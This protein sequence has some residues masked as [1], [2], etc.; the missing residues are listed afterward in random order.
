M[1][2][3]GTGLLVA[4][5]LA[6]CAGQLTEVGRAPEMAP[7]G[8]GLQPKVDPTSPNSFPAPQ[9]TSATSLWDDNR[10][11]LFRDPRANRV[12]D[13][14]TVLIAMD[15]KATL[16]NTSDRSTTSTIGNGADIT[17]T[18]STA[19]TTGSF[20]LDSTSKSAASGTGSVDRSEKIQLSVGAVV[21]GVLPNGNLLISGS[22]EVR[23]NYELRQLQ[24]AGIVRP[25]DVSKDN[26]IAYDKIAEA[27]ISYGGRGR[28]S[29]VQ[30]PGWGQ[31]VYDIVKP[32]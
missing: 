32:F 7:V 8:A 16:D 30:Q 17:V 29:E 25:R 4:L 2:R 14:I 5:L 10:A 26:T 11:N 20:Q 1:I 19:K 24:V 3:I 6:G 13:V 12:G 22:Q 15:E 28:I 18:G 27:R 21:S 9:R 31:Q 23:V